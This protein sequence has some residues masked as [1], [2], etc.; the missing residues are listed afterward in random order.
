[1][2]QANITYIIFEGGLHITN[3]LVGME[4]GNIAHITFEGVLHIYLHHTSLFS[5]VVVG[6]SCLTNITICIKVSSPIKRH[7]KYGVHKV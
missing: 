7:I 1:M 2:K 6:Y 5:A 4:Q 3:K